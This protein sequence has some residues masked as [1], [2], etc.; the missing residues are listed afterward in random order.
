[1]PRPKIGDVV[2]IETDLGYFYALYTHQHKMFG[3]LLRVFGRPFATRPGNFESLVLE[4]PQFETFFPLGAAVRR[5]IVAVAGTATIPKKLKPF[6]IFRDGV[7]D[8]LTGKVSNW[9]LWDG[10]NEW[11]V[12]KLNAEQ[13]KYPMREA[14][15]DTLLKERVKSGWRSTDEV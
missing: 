6:P 11:L 2:E 13:E 12:G 5:K 3:A 10:E 8:R 9:W 1:M 7:A 4:E 14:I 15:N